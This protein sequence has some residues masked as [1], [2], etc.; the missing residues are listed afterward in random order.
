MKIVFV[1]FWILV[2]FVFVYVD[3]FIFFRVDVING[4]LQHKVLGV[5]FMID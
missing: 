2:L 1:G 5:D 3:I 4:V